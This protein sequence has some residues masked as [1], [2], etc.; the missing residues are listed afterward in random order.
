MK[1][2]RLYLS[3][4]VLILL[5]VSMLSLCSCVYGLGGKEV[6]EPGEEVEVGVVK[7]TIGDKVFLKSAEYATLHDLLT[8]MVSIG[9]ISE[10]KYDEYDGMYYANKIDTLQDTSTKGIMI[11]HNIEDDN[12][13]S[14]NLMKRVDGVTFRLAN[15]GTNYL[16]TNA[17]C[18]YII[19]LENY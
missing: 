6:D 7:L 15:V 14:A 4:F 11:Y 10:Y 17:P 12:L 3:I 18:E 9:D 16:P 2:K 8:Y 5:I 19:L 1:T 13:Y